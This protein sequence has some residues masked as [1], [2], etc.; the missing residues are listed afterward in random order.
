MVLDV[1]FLLTLGALAEREPGVN[2]QRVEVRQDSEHVY[3]LRN[4]IANDGSLLPAIT[5]ARTFLVSFSM[6]R[7][8]VTILRLTSLRRGSLLSSPISFR[9]SIPPRSGAGS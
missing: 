7:W 1:F 9:G 3:R 5:A 8:S 4:R 6:Q 2:E